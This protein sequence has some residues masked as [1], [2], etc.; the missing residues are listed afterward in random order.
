MLGVFIADGEHHDV[1][2]TDP[3]GGVVIA[4]ATWDRGRSSRS[5]RRVNHLE[6]GIHRPSMTV[7]IMVLPY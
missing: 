6:C 1:Q 5:I 7:I 3:D 4:K 2:L